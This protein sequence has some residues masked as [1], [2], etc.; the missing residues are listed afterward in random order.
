MSFWD[1][2]KT[3]ETTAAVFDEATFLKAWEQM[4][5]QLKQPRRRHYH[6]ISSRATPGTWTR[7]S[8]CGGP[9]LVPEDWGARA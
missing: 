8:S 7:C 9:V 4:M 5:K 6:L 1:S 3:N 2:V